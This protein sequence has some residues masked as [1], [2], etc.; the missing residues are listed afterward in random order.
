MYVSLVTLVLL[1]PLIDPS[2]FILYMY[3][4]IHTYVHI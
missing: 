1:P 3:L 4:F 2:M